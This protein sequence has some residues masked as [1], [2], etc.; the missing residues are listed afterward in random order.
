MPFDGMYP[1]YDGNGLFAGGGTDLFD[2]LVFLAWWLSAVQST[3]QGQEKAMQS[4]AAAVADIECLL[5]KVVLPPYD[6]DGEQG[7]S[8]KHV[9]KD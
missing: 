3:K 4:L 2:A 9:W 8:N 7:A 6:A 1:L 5:R